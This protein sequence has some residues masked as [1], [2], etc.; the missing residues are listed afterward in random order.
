MKLPLLSLAATLL[1]CAHSASAK[2][3]VLKMVRRKALTFPRLRKFRRSPIPKH[4]PHPS[5]FPKVKMKPTPPPIFLTLSRLRTAGLLALA[6]TSSAIASGAPPIAIVP[7]EIDPLVKASPYADKPVWSYH[8]KDPIPWAL[9]KPKDYGSTKVQFSADGVR[10]VGRVPAPGVHPRMFFSPEDLPALRQ[11]FKEDVAAQAAW[12]NILCWTNALK[13]T[14]DEKADYAQ[15]DWGVGFGIK[16]RVPSLF[17]TGGYNPKRE[18]YYKIL[19]EGGS[20]KIYEKDSP[21]GFFRPG[22]CEAFRCLIDDDRAGAETLGK[23][24][25][26]AIKLEQA[27]RAQNDKPVEAGQPPRPST[28]RTDACS[29]GFI[30]DFVFNYLTPDQKKI[31]HDELVTLSSWADNYGSFNNA[32]ASRSNWATFSYWVF[33]LMAIEGEPGFNDLKYL[34]LYRGWR[35]FY[36]Y[37]FFDSGAAFEAEGKLLFGLDAAVT[38]D[39]VAYKY[40]LELLTQHPLPRSYYGKFSAYAMLPT[41]DK[42]AVFDILGHMGGS[43]TTP[44]DLVVA[45]Y[46]F[47]NDKTTDFVYRALVHDDYKELPSSLHSLSHQAIT[48]AIFATAYSPEIDPEKLNLGQSFFCGQRALMMTRS[49]WDRN[50]TLLTMHTRGASGGHP[51]PDRNGIMLAAQGRTWITIPG[52]DQGP[53]ACSTV[54]VDGA[55]QTP[56]TPARVVDYVDQ[57]QA[58]FM[59]GDAKYCWDWVWGVAGKTKDGKEITRQDVL[60]DNV[61]T[62]LSWKLVEQSFNDFAW[63]KTDH[64]VYQRPMKFNNHW[65]ALDGVLAPYKR[66]INTPVLKSFRTAGVV[67]GPRPYVLVVDD[68]QRDAMPTQYDWN[69]TLESDVVELKV[70]KGLGAEG[71]IILVGKA[72]LDADGS[73]KPGEPALLIRVLQCEGKR[74]PAVIGLREKWNLLSIRTVAS[75]PDFKVLLYAFKAGDPLPKT[76][77]NTKRTAVSVSFQEQKDVITFTPSSAGKTDV[78]LQRGADFLAQVN[79]HVPLLADPETDALTARVRQIPARLAALRTQSCDPA[80]QPGFL[81]GWIFDKA[82]NGSFSPL[83]GSNPTAAS[84]PLGKAKP[85]EGMNGRQAVAIGPEPLQSG[86]DFAKDMKAGPFTVSCWLKTKAGPQTGEYLKI[87]DLV[88]LGFI[89]GN[90]Q[91]NVG[92]VLNDTWPASMLSSWTHVVVTFDGTVVCTYRNGALMSSA[93]FPANGKLNWGKKFSLGGKSSY[94]DAE[95]SAQSLYF[96]KTAFT[97]EAVEN[98]Y[99]WGKYGLANQAR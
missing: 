93:A 46:L 89:Q 84:V 6:L 13:L 64:P 87:D 14:Y 26:T 92:R 47:P 43:F 79:K 10:S 38:M 21:A 44:Q 11:R 69:L 98:L 41:R 80:K 22:A 1:L 50:A 12:K 40:G 8:G 39:R 5:S 34:A 49:S 66:Q 75:S 97:P 91:V 63:T 82:V 62:G 36:T 48:S 57:P 37:S 3:P 94:G 19:A 90:L 74:Q 77:W 71:D 27:R 81:A 95:V 73:L 17:R 60:N 51:Y 78:V 31:M 70:R 85:V 35:N 61:D 42:F 83:A 20:P 23:A 33:D 4:R 72:S 58:T 96:Y 56:S 67:R 76:V 54:V 24:T 2:L 55:G 7:T 16:G 99:L 25:V 59:T 65:L 32:E 9:F 88:N 86:L 29:L 18:D 52:K 68:V 28:S 30:Y 15:P 53:W 45:H